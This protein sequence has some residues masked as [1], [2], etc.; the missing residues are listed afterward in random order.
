MVKYEYFKRVPWEEC[1]LGFQFSMTVCQRAELIPYGST[2]ALFEQLLAG[3]YPGT[4]V[5]E[6]KIMSVP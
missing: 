4:R 2:L 3:W 5:V 1:L 6:K